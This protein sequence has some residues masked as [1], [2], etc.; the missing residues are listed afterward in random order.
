MNNNTL[1]IFKTKQNNKVVYGFNP[2]YNNIDDNVIYPDLESINDNIDVVVFVVNP[3]IGIK[4]LDEVINKNIKT[5]W[6][7]PDTESDELMNSSID[8]LDKISKAFKI[9]SATLLIYNKDHIVTLS[10]V[11]QKK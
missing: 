5:I 3:K 7:Q 6:L 1:E 9:E 8:M 2:K 11:D 10:R 4:Y